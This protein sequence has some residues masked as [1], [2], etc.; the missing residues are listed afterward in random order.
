MEWIKPVMWLVLFGFLTLSFLPSS[1]FTTSSSR[2]PVKILEIFTSQCPGTHS[3]CEPVRFLP[4]LWFT[5]RFGKWQ[6]Q[7]LWPC[8]F[9]HFPFYPGSFFLFF[10]LC[11]ARCCLFPYSGQ[12]QLQGLVWKSQRAHNRVSCRHIAVIKLD[13]LN[14]ASGYLMSVL[15][16]MFWF[17]NRWL[18][19]STSSGHR[20]CWGPV[21][22]KVPT[23]KSTWIPLPSASSPA[24]MSPSS[25]RLTPWCLSNPPLSHHFHCYSFIQPRSTMSYLNYGSSF[26]PFYGPVSW[27]AL[28]TPVHSPSSRWTDCQHL[29]CRYDSALYL[30]ESLLLFFLPFQEKSR[31]F[32]MCCKAL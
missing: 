11:S 5:P 18:R 22:F 13:D 10:W 7:L 6:K 9:S 3:P 17:G 12:G 31:A 25:M 16:F 23:W 21:G 24:S 28:D 4:G 2:V 27:L 30:L 8:F 26:L 32:Y 19:G 1:L 14:V 29:N 15:G 20:V